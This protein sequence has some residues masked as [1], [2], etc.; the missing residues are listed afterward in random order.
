MLSRAVSSETPRVAA[1]CEHQ[2]KF[3]F[4]GLVIDA[5]MTGRPVGVTAEENQLALA[6]T[7]DQSQ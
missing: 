4:T 6:Q 1:V 2:Y 3:E 7:V 5:S